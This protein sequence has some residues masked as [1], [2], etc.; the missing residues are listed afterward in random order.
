MKL[1]PLLFV[2]VTV[3]LP[4]A[5]QAEP[6]MKASP[7]SQ[8]APQHPKKAPKTTNRPGSTPSVD[9]AKAAT[10][11]QQ[12][13]PLPVDE[14]HAFA[15][16]FGRIKN[17]Y[18]EEVSD[19]KLIK[20]AIVGMLSGLDPHSTYLDPEEYKEL[21]EGTT[22]TFGG[23][24]IEVGMEDGFVKVITPIDDTPAK[25]AGIQAGDLIIRLDDQ[26]VKGMAL[27]DSVKLMRGEPGTKLR[28]T[29]IREG[30]DKPFEVTIERAEIKVKSVKYESLEPGYAYVRIT[31]FQARTYQDLKAAIKALTADEQ[32]IKGLVL[33]L[34]NNPGGVLNAAVAVSDAFLEDG[35]VVYT[36]GRRADSQV[37]FSAGPGDLISGAPII[38]LVN[39]GSASAAEIVAGALQDRKRAIIMGRQTFGKGSVQTVIP[40]G[41]HGAVKLTT[42][43]YFT[44]SG[45]SIQAEGISPDIPLEQLKMAVREPKTQLGQVKEA[46]L[47]HHL[48]NPGGQAGKK[49]T[50]LAAKTMENNNKPDSKDQRP[51]VER[52]YELY[53]ALTLLKGLAIL[54]QKHVQTV[55][56]QKQ[57]ATKA[58]AP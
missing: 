47:A 56:E 40:V 21:Q 58:K 45:R 53:Q 35:L 6:P 8:K 30:R 19:K 46:N 17:D 25:A 15:E 52:D 18:V 16:I 10:P 23:L 24:G 37:R 44:P 38:V 5:T 28:L 51:L 20:Q 3:I 54:D 32:M 36:Q 11:A 33:D 48:D 29:I 43:R 1:K 50:G 2:L 49:P 12:A 31:T 9:K 26:S 4:L 13:D 57:E 7:A 55:V 42:A 41:K 14:L 22:G 34:R 39:G 27:G